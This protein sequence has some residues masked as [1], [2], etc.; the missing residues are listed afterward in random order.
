MGK[1]YA[2]LRFAKIKS[3]KDFK[4]TYNHNM[5][6]YDVSNADKMRTHLN[7]EPVDQ[8]NGQ[9]YKEAYERTEAQMRAQGAIHGK[10]R[11]D[12]VR[13][14]E[15]I[16]RY[17]H[18]ADEHIDHDEWVKANV[19]WLREHFNPPGGK[20]VFTVD[21][22]QKEMDI[23]NVKSVIVHN[24][25]GVP[26][27]HAFIVPIDDKGHLN[28]GY[29]LGGRAKLVDMQNSYAQAM[30]R[31]GLER[32]EYKSIATPEK[33]AR[34]LSEITKATDATLP[35][36]KQE[37]SK[38]EY[39]ERA[40]RAFQNEK[41]HHRDEI[42]KQNQENIRLRSEMVHQFDKTHRESWEAMKKLKKLA[43]K[44][45]LQKIDEEAI[46]RIRGAVEDH[47]ALMQAVAEE[48]PETGNRIM[49]RAAE[50]MQSAAITTKR[51]GRKK[52]QQLS[53]EYE[54]R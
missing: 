21:G 12:A 33:I 24:D 32:G 44:M 48:D 17:S 42:V 1:E 26:H 16:L 3:D 28:S 30:S 10:T 23:D 45:D 5:R 14:I 19:E 9:T 49:A 46:E 41:I 2:I 7:E 34:Y 27:I 50:I 29:Y 40:N 53:P 11:E 22:V 37:E 47:S 18:E 39:Y 15:L 43:K 35:P 6:I 4:D 25:E 8:L 52:K 31:F 36:P 13:G 38:E 54:D 20:A 51:R